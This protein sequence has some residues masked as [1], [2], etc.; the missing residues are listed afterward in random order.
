M[1]ESGGHSAMSLSFPSS[2]L[3]A[4]ERSGCAESR[5]A[6]PEAPA[7]FEEL[8]ERYLEPVYN[9]LL[10]LTG[11]PQD[12]EDLTQE[13]FLRAWRNL[14][15]FRKGRPFAAW[16]FTVAR[17]L[18]YNHFRKRK[19]EALLGEV[20]PE[21]FGAIVD[22]PRNSGADG[23]ALWE[24]TSRLPPAEREAL[25]LRYGEGLDVARISRIMGKSGVAVRV[26][27][28]RGRTR[29]RAILEG[30]QIGREL[31]AELRKENP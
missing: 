2:P 26:L 10:R 18:A 8:I 29:M 31:S 14:E 24:L 12:A 16:V 20:A 27:L 6:A 25:W 4:E 19:P 5:P 21:R 15:K 11:H 17:N 23:A 9:Y 3:P 13:T 22:Q 30:T 1:P 28:H 7:S